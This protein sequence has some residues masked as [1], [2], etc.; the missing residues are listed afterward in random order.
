MLNENLSGTIE[1]DWTPRLW[2]KIKIQPEKDGWYHITIKFRKNRIRKN[3]YK[4]K[5][6]IKELKK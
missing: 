2:K 4:F 3:K 5:T 6:K 1:F